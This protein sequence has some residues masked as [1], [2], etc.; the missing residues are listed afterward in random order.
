[1][2]KSFL[3]GKPIRHPLHPV[4]IHF[5]IGLFVLS[6]LLDLGSFVAK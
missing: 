4:L 3:Q 1:M 6:L 5:P 2:L